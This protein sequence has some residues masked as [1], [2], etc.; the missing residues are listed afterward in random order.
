MSIFLDA[1]RLSL[2]MLKVTG[3][4][5]ESRSKKV[6]SV[7]LPFLQESLDISLDQCLKTVKAQNDR[8]II[9]GTRNKPSTLKV[10]FV[11]D[12]TTFG[13]PLT[14][15]VMFL[16]PK[17]GAFPL[18]VE[19]QINSLNSICYSSKEANKLNYL[20]IQSKNMPLS[21]TAAGTFHCLLKTMK[22][23]NELADAW[24]DRVKAL[25]E[26]EFKYASK[27]DKAASSLNPAALTQNLLLV[28]GAGMAA[29]AAAAYGTSA[30]SGAL[31]KSNDMDSIRGDKSGENVKAPPKN[32]NQ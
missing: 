18:S 29:A 27:Q 31:A 16:N 2:P 17:S 25:V 32:S 8:E 30:M 22:V 15:P 14:A 20:T 11:L 1:S 23:K 21:H 28:A 13:T 7:S 3:F 12:D 6:G 5:D 19:N 24:G 10:T 9:A 26:C 4:E